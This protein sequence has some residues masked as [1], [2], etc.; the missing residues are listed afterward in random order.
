M[1]QQPT[2][3]DRSERGQIL[4]LAA[5]LMVILIGITG[6][7]IDIS[8]AYM[9]DRWQRAVADAASLAGGQ[10]LQIPGSRAA[11]GANEQDAARR[12]AMEVLV[13]ELRATSTPSTAVGSACLDPGGC[14]LP[15]TPYVVSIRTP[16]PSFV[17]CTPIRCIQVSVRQPSFG[18]TFARIFGQQNWSVNTTSVAGIV[19]TR[20]YGL[21]TL[22]PPDPRG[23]T[24]NADDIVVKGGSKVVIGGA[25]AATN[26][27]LL[28]SGLA[29]GSELRLDPGFSLFHWDPYEAWFGPP[30]QC[31]NPPTGEQL[32]SPVPDPDYPIPNAARDGV[33]IGCPTTT[34]TVCSYTAANLSDAQ[35]SA[36]DCATE[37]ATNVPPQ[38]NVTPPNTKCY[39]PGI[40]TKKLRD[41]QNTDI[42]LLT[43]G[44]YFFNAGVDISGSLIG[45]YA[46][47]GVPGVALVLPACPALNCPD[48]AGN[49]AVLVALNFGSAYLNPSGT[50]ATAADWDRGSVETTTDPPHL[51]TILVEPDQNC[52][53]PDFPFT[54]PANSCSNRQPQIKLPGGGHLWVAGVQYAP[55]DNTTVTGSSPQQGVLGQ[56][57]S[58]TITFDGN[59][60]LNLLAF[61]L[62]ELGVL[63]LD[64]ACSP[65]VSTCN[66]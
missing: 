9:A 29:A 23:G 15:G 3:R 64:P 8:A 2:T 37:I 12:H 14:P 58:W 16:T 4:V 19:Q 38:Y 48:F 56:I 30:G 34:T 46:R 10:D 41:S 53:A 22:R 52:L 45:G 42:S 32:T 5:L 11:P 55:T 47:A 31:A 20:Q 61:S 13:S 40:Y 35:L 7:A 63:R 36:A 66:P 6:L 27:N 28:C 51:M 1:T 43:P 62:D 44:V 54:E 17:D 39:K 57:V 21:V 26:T 18:L 60:T 65:T 33:S 49:N 59:S 25:D 24:Q 50:Q